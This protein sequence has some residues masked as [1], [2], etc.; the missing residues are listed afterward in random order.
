M[1]ADEDPTPIERMRPTGIDAE[2]DNIR[3]ELVEELDAADHQ[4]RRIAHLLQRVDMLQHAHKREM[5]AANARIADL[6]TEV[7][8]L[9]SPLA[10]HGD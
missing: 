2:L 3:H 10:A 4:R 1:I 9:R 7:A 6:E 5:A 8:A